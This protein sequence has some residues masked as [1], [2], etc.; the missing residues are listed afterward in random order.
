MT[1]NKMSIGTSLVKATRIS[2]RWCISLRLM[3]IKVTI[4]YYTFV[5]DSR[6]HASSYLPEVIWFVL[7]HGTRPCM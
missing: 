5:S 7:V 1:T 3:A 6:I 2:N 4:N